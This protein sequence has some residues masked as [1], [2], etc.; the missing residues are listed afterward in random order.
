MRLPF[1][2]PLL[3]A[4][5]FFYFLFLSLTGFTALHECTRKLSSTATYISATDTPC[6]AVSLRQLI[7]CFLM[8]RYKVSYKLP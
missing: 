3:F 5:P 8:P 4:L 7:T 1:L 6:S 2:I